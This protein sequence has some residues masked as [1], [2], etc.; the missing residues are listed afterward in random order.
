MTSILAHE[1][2]WVIDSFRA[3]LA[4]LPEARE[5]RINTGTREQLA[6]GIWVVRTRRWLPA[7]ALD[8]LAELPTV[9]MELFRPA[10]FPILEWQERADCRGMGWPQFFG[11]DDAVQQPS[12]P[13]RQL[14]ETQAICASCQALRD[15]FTWSLRKGETHG[16][17][18]GMSGRQRKPILEKLK[19]F[20]PVDRE[21]VIDEIADAWLT[22]K[23]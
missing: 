5:P 7:S 20:A 1:D 18:G 19:A 21:H 15:C 11:K 9:G 8:R 2:E 13:L 3:E 17:W 23:W 4:A 6:P 16:I 22:S 12:L 10:N 14:R